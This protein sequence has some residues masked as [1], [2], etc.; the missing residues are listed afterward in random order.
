M[1][2]KNA[3]APSYLR[4]IPLLEKAA[5]TRVRAEIAR[6][7]TEHGFTLSDQQLNNWISRGVPEKSCIH[8]GRILNCSPLWLFFG[9]ED[10]PLHVG[11]N[12]NIYEVPLSDEERLVLRA[13]RRASIDARA[14]VLSW[15]R[16]QIPPEQ[17]FNG[18]T[19]TH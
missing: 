17:N 13:F 10:G 6:W 18:R 14:F 2:R 9:P 3:E 4:L 11:N 5:G 16:D 12:V 8:L 7:C 1:K 15:A 19:G